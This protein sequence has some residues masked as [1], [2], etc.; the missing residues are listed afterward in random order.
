[1]R[2]KDRQH[3]RR[4]LRSLASLVLLAG[5]ARA[6]E[7][8]VYTDESEYPPL[9]IPQLRYIKMD[10]EAEQISDKSSQGGT[11]TSQ[12]L[13]LSPGVGIGW[14]YF[15]YHPNLMTFSLLA[16]P[17]YTWQQFKQDGQTSLENS[18]TVNGNFT[19]TV[20]PLK[21]F[22]TILNYNRSHGEYH[23]DFFNSAT[24]DSEM[25]GLATGYRQGPV[26]FTVGYQHMQTDSSGLMYSSQTKQDTIN[27]HAQSERSRGNRSDLSYQFNTYNSIAGGFLNDTTTHYLTLTD[28]E[29]FRKSSLNTSFYY[30]HLEEDGQVSD[31]PTL[32]LGFNWQHTPHLRSFY[33]ASVADY[34]TSGAEFVNGLARVGLQ[35]QLYE[36]L[37]STVDV[38][39][40][41]S[42]SDSFGSKLN[43]T[44]MG[45]SLAE[46]YAKRLGGWGQLTLNENVS[47]DKTHQD[48]TGSQQLIPNESYAVPLSGIFVL[49]SPRDISVQTVTYNDGVVTH[50]LSAG[51]GGDY[52][53]IT[54]TDPWQI[55]VYSTGPNHVPVSSGIVQVQVT[56]LIQPNPSGSYSTFNNQAEVRLSFWQSRAG[57][58]A[59]YLIDQSEADLP[60]F[61]LENTCE[62]ETGA[63]LN[64]R[65]LR[66][67]A[68]YNDRQST[69]YDYK[70]YTLSESYTLLATG[71]QN[72]GLNFNQQWSTFSNADGAPDQSHNMSFYSF[73]ANYGWHPF[74]SLGWNTQ[75][76][77]QQQRG[78][79]LDQE[80][81]I[82]RTDLTWN[83][84]KLNFKIGY[85]FDQTKYLYETRGR[86]YVYLN[87]MRRF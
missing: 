39:G 70:S 74:Y 20:L 26:P 85:Q 79:G 15:L 9:T 25:W 12:R 30:N 77:Y 50:T 66:L 81:M 47:Y 16:E 53:V 33:D 37:T 3:Q 69:L 11:T 18:L 17:A 2:A 59:R 24:V 75:A 57:I 46:A 10:V 21:P 56:Y 62:F 78:I 36:S 58:Y 23:Y 8:S 7:Q 48:S 67:D 42:S 5:T 83:V 34:S 84:G 19:G 68:A 86:N 64:W 65:D 40:T 32:S 71:R 44:T 31:N 41:E 60:G 29:N 76:G 52:D 51:P 87:M 28:T 35:H 61:V 73:T 13:Y 38:H 55:Q 14:D 80:T 49:K 82:L 6:V 72:A 63:D 22:S 1:M 54:T 27:L 4:L 45:S 43:S